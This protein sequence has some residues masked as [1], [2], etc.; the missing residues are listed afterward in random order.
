MTIHAELPAHRDLRR[1]R[2]LYRALGDETR[3]RVIGLLAELGPVAGHRA[4]LACGALP[5]AHQLAPAHPAGRRH[6]RHRAAG[7]HGHLPAAAGRLRG[8]SR[9]GGSA[10]RRYLGHRGRGRATGSREGGRCPLVGSMR[11]TWR[12]ADRSCPSWVKD[13]ARAVLAPVVRMALALHIT[14]NTV[15]VIGFFIVMVAAVGDRLSAASSPGALILTAGSLLDAVDGAL[16]RATG[17]GT[18]VRQLPRL[19][20]RSRGGGDPLPGRGGLLPGAADARP[21]R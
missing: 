19:D 20:P 1:L 11:R 15:T 5:A 4:L 3:L 13:T 10:H 2:T 21:G 14:P 8:A 6:H 16:A 7:T 17:G 9:G 18:A 12:A